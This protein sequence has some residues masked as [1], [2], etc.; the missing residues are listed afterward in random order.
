MPERERPGK[1]HKSSPSAISIIGVLPMSVLKGKYTVLIPG[2]LLLAAVSLFLW[3]SSGDGVPAAAA[4]VS[5]RFSAVILDAGHGGADGGTV[6][7][8]GTVEKNINLA[9]VLA[10]KDFCDYLGVDTVLTRDGDFS[11]GSGDTLRQQKS[12]DLKR[13]AE[14]VNSAGAAVLISVHQNYYDDYVSRGPQVFYNSENAFGKALAERMQAKLTAVCGGGNSRKAMALPN[15]NYLLT[16]IACPAVIVECGFL[17]HLEEEMLLNSPEYRST[18]AFAVA[19]E[20]LDCVT[21][22]LGFAGQS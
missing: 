1:T 5:R 22:G 11:L 21:S 17:S 6:G 4:P 16:H 8:S 18:L 3:R 14:I 13:R 2:A 20:A 15:E 9:I 19:A 12:S 10:A 7:R